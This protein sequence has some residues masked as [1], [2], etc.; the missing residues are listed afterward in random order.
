MKNL[1]TVLGIEA[2]AVATCFII[3]A[4]HIDAPEVARW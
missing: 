1:K 2:L 4:N 3:A